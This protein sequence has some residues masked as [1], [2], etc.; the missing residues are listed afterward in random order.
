MSR[1]STSEKVDDNPDSIRKRIETLRRENEPTLAH[2]SL[3][4]LVKTVRQIKSSLVQSDNAV[5][6]L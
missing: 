2:L 6:Q 1:A 3:H 4:H 5:D